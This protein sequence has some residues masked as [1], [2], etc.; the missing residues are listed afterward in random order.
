MKLTRNLR[1]GFGRVFM[2][3]VGHHVDDTIKKI[4]LEGLDIS[5]R[6]TGR[7]SIDGTELFVQE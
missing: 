2:L 4:E 6:K 3:R 7:H 1:T 5:E